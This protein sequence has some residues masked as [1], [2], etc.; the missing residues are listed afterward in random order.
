MSAEEP[1]ALGV[2]EF[3]R[4]IEEIYLDRDR[5][6]GAWSTYAWFVE[7]VGELA[8]A[9]RGDDRANLEE[10]FADCFAW[11]VTLA[12]IKGIDLAEA[13]Q[14]YAKGCPRC[15]G[16]P[17]QCEHREVSQAHPSV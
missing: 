15:H 12:S 6:R 17:C 14:K 4:R 3:Q 5:S 11:L 13:A 8:R 2:R 9:L 1:P 16:I 10:E 7:E